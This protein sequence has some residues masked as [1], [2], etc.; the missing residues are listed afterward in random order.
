MILATAAVLGLGIGSAFAGDGDIPQ[1]G[2]FFS[3]LPGVVAQAPVQQ[4]PSAYAQAPAGQTRSP[5]A[6]FATSHNS[7]TWFYQN[8]VH[9]GNNS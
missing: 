5:T 8:T 4:A 7:G 1:T 9:E 2:T 3:N 6:V